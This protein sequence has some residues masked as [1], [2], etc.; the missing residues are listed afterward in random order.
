MVIE[1]YDKLSKLVIKLLPVKPAL[2]ANLSNASDFKNMRVAVD[3]KI[4]YEAMHSAK[5]AASY[6]AL[7]T[8]YS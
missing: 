7:Y 8:I 3:P 1:I 5:T 4:T 2:Q 6:I